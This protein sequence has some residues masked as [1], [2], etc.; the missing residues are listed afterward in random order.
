MAK[1]DAWRDCMNKY[2]KELLD[3]KLEN[4]DYK[5]LIET[6]MDL[7]KREIDKGLLES[8][9]KLYNVDLEVLQDCLK[10]MKYRD[11]FDHCEIETRGENGEITIKYCL[12]LKENWSEKTK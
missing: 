7:L 11:F 10:V 6:I 4:Y 8:K 3:Y 2:K 5:H 12:N 9:I 1:I